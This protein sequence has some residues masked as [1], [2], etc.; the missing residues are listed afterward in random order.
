MQI[1]YE[2][3]PSKADVSMMHLPDH[4]GQ[5]R[6]LQST[7]EKASTTAFGHL[8]L[9]DT[10]AKTL[11]FLQFKGKQQAFSVTIYVIGPA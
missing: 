4:Q 6:G 2:W 8:W 1:N 3:V 5:N 10:P 7:L 9:K 11:F